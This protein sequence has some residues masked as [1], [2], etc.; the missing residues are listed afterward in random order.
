MQAINCVSEKP[1]QEIALGGAVGGAPAQGL[2]S[3][4]AAGTIYLFTG[5]CPTVFSTCLGS[6]HA[7]PSLYDVRAL[8]T[9]LTP[10]VCESGRCKSRALLAVTGCS[11]G[12]KGMSSVAAEAGEGCR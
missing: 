5:M 11:V 4:E 1:V 3:D 2:T 12:T 7:Q 8:W 10:P 6:R 9:M